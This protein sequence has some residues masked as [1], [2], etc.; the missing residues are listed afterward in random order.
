MRLGPIARVL[1]S[2]TLVLGSRIDAASAAAPPRLI[3]EASPRYD[4]EI[5][6]MESI[7]PDRVRSVMDLVGLEDG[8]DPIRVV[9]AAEDHPLAR[10]VP[11]PIAGYAVPE[12]DL[13]VLLPEHVPSYPYDSLEEVLLHELTHVL[14]SRA[15]GGRALPRWWNEGLA[16]LASRGWSLEDRSRVLFGAVAG[17][18]D[19]A[20][21]EASFERGA[22]QSA[23]Y[24]IS[25]A[26]VH[27]LVRRHG[28]EVVAATHARVA[29]GTDFETAFESAAGVVAGAGRRAILAALPLLVSLGA[30]P[31][32]RGRA[33]G[34]RHRSRDPRRR[35][36]PSPRRGDPTKVGGRGAARRDGQRGSRD[37]ELSASSAAASPEPHD[38]DR[39]YHSNSSA[40][41]DNE[42][43]HAHALGG[44]DAPGGDGERRRRAAAAGHAGHRV[45]QPRMRGPS[46]RPTSWRRPTHRSSRSVAPACPSDLFRLVVEYETD[47]TARYRA[48]LVYAEPSHRLLFVQWNGPPTAYERASIDEAPLAVFETDSQ[49]RYATI[50]FRPERDDRILVQAITPWNERRD[51]LTGRVG[52]LCDFAVENRVHD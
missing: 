1:L 42:V 28:V 13:A 29:S 36:T 37:G 14:A 17:V 50:R 45:E 34:E 11:S 18:A 39:R 31:H 33:V 5:E 8:G 22:Q 3:F 46:S 51:V 4:S 48:L 32:Q 23:A 6:R 49:R 40:R 2:G 7:A 30:L 12:R 25:G 20:A 9:I 15:A 24:A 44:D 19:T 10:E 52:N 41:N 35:A 47:G 26:L 27:H 21:L 38:A 16:L 43:G